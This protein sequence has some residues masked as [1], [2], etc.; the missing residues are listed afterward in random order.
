MGSITKKKLVANAISATNSGS[1]GVK[2][3]CGLISQ[4]GTG[5]PSI[6][7]VHDDFNITI[8]GVRNG[9]GDFELNLSSPILTTHKTIYFLNLG[10]TPVNSGGAVGIE[11]IDASTF[12]ISATDYIGSIPADGYLVETPFCFYV[13]P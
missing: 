13:Y 12:V 11:R 5:N 1:S 8:T 3:W 2:V 6:I 10:A 9:A 7:E 4:N